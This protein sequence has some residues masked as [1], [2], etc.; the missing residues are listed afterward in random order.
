M[1]G[2]IYFDSLQTPSTQ[3]HAVAIFFQI[4][5]T[6]SIQWNIFFNLV[7]DYIYVIWYIFSTA[8]LWNSP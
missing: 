8:A 1:H 7:S 2:V 3:I 4:V 6:K 5:K